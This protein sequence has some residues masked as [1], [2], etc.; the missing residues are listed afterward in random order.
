MLVLLSS[1]AS[2]MNVEK[3]KDLL[4]EYMRE[5]PGQRIWNTVEMGFP[6]AR[7]GSNRMC[8]SVT[9]RRWLEAT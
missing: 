1:S 2:L 7:A 5:S 6:V 9:R 8:S 4:A 3:D